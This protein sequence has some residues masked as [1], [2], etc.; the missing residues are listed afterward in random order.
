MSKLIVL[1]TGATDGIGKE[2]ARKLLAKNYHVVIVGR[3]EQRCIQTIEEISTPATRERIDYMLCDLSS[4]KQLH[5]LADQFH[6]EYEHLDVL[7]NNAG[8][9]N[10]Q[11]ETT[12]E[13]LEAT[14]AINH[15]S[16]FTLTLLLMDVLKT[17]LPSR[18]INVSSM[19]HMDASMYWDDLQ[20]EHQYDGYLAYAQSKLANVLFTY[21]LARRLDKKGMTVNCLHPGVISTKLLHAGFAMGGAS[22]V[23][24]AQTSVY[25]ATSLEVAKTNGKYFVDSRERKSSHSSYNEEYQKRLWEI[26]EQLTGLNANDYLTP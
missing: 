3:S 11:R 20:L 24:G 25:L 2:T 19:V 14:F 22:V 1:I 12:P 5:Q 9:F 10:N 18:I 17:S 4:Q 15:L 23:K 16:Y 6:Q 21:E 8:V 13:G 26:S 7:I